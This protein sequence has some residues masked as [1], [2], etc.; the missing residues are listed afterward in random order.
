MPFPIEVGTTA[1]TGLITKAEVY[2]LTPPG[3]PATKSI[4][5]TDQQWGVRVEWEMCGE[6][7]EWLN[8]EFHV[9]AFA[10]GIGSAAPDYDLAVVVVPSL[11]GAWNPV[12]KKRRYSV[13]LAGPTVAAGTYK[14]TATVQLHEGETHAPVPV[15][16][17]AECTM[18]QFYNP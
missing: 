4:I 15:A 14:I 12:E 11:N 1:Y 5:R 2:E 3:V 9:Q 18:V 17:F 7:A 8:D 13:E 16:G 10:E 6:L